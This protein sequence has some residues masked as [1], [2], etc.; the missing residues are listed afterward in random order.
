[1]QFVPSMRA[2]PVLA[3]ALAVL[4]RAEA[5]RPSVA[6]EAA[7]VGLDGTPDHET[8]TPKQVGVL[9]TR[10][11]A[12]DEGG[13]WQYV[14]EEGGRAVARVDGLTLNGGRELVILRDARLGKQRLV[15]TSRWTWGATPMLQERY[16][17]RSRRI[18]GRGP[19]RRM[20]GYGIDP[21]G[22]PRYTPIP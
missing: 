14:K 15:V 19:L 5:R 13:R 21:A 11:W 18:S 3:I 1:M 7:K 22:P 2:L 17:E 10:T 12:N 20:T 4:P 16:D 6:R 8:T 9:H